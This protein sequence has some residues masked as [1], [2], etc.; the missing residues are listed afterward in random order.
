MGL[1]FVKD[2]KLK[3]KHVMEILPNLVPMSAVKNQ[4]LCRFGD[5]GDYFYIILSGNCSIW[6][7][8]TND[9]VF[10]VIKE[11]LHVSEVQ[12]KNSID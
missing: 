7:P 11:I 12:N 1:K 5:I 2:F 8:I 10:D 3:E 6:T 4:I 9:K